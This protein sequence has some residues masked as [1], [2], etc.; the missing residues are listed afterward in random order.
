VV[1]YDLRGLGRSTGPKDRQFDLDRMAD[2]LLA[3]MDAIGGG[4]AVLIGH[5]IGGMIQLTLAKGRPEEF[6]RR[7]AGLVIAHSTP[8]NPTRTTQL[9]DL[10]AALQKPVLEPLAWL[11]VLFAP[12]VWVM[13]VFSYLNGS[14][15]WSNFRVAFSWTGTWA[16]VEFVTRYT[17]EIWPAPYARGCLGMFRYDAT[18]ALAR[19]TV[20][21][22]VVAADR[23]RMTVLAA[24]EAIR[25]GIPRA[26]M[27]TLSPAGHMGP[28]QRPDELAAA[29][30]S[31]LDRHH[32]TDQAGA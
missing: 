13:N 26:E 20:P 8:T 4:P 25:A 1:A 18:D 30:R 9:G 28:I 14:S 6:G 17:L 12:L 7:V 3:V 10:L 11:M 16:Q 27:A 22:L 19:I 23:D 31:F 32:R 15:H 29:V 5:S 2:D 21:T 24:N